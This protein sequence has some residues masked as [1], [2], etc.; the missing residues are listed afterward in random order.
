M[1]A[2][3]CATCALVFAV[4]AAAATAEVDADAGEPPSQDEHP[5]HPP[6]APAADFDE[7]VVTA[8]PHARRRFDVIQGTTVL[9]HEALEQA[10]RPSLGDTLG[11]LPGISSSS[12]GPRSPCCSMVATSSLESMLP[13]SERSGS[14]SA[15]K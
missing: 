1:L 8:T 9:D 14:M 2:R 5:T 12:F 10:L 7:I 11:N 4:A 15:V 3:C 6:I 13:A